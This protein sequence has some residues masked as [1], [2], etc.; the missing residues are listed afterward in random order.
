MSV[1][2]KYTS[3]PV[4]KSALQASFL[5]IIKAIFL[6][7]KERLRMR[8]SRNCTDLY[9]TDIHFFTKKKVVTGTTKSEFVVVLTIVFFWG[10]GGGGCVED[11]NVAALL[12]QSAG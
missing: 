6:L 4:N 1:L 8:P 5:V 2:P 10:E 11:K 3:K 7:E 12:G 9:C